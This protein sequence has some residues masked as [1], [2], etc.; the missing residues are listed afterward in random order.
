MN[1]KVLCAI[2][3]SMAF[4]FSCGNAV[5]AMRPGPQLMYMVNHPQD[6]RA[7]AIDKYLKNNPQSFD[8]LHK[9]SVRAVELKRHKVTAVIAKH[10]LYAA[11]D[12]R[13]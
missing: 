3:S 4:A 2:V 8:V 12:T 6:H 13:G 11:V 5:R 10:L 1:N 9:A 7:H